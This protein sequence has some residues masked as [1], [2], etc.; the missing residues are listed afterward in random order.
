VVD[1]I[2]IGKKVQMG[3]FAA[4]RNQ[5]GFGR[6]V[7]GIPLFALICFESRLTKG[8]ETRTNPYVIGEK[9]PLQALTGP[10]IHMHTKH[11]TLIP[12]DSLSS[13]CTPH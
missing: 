5:R 9:Y 3:G 1:G 7:I 13:A 2:K 12:K 4:F 8:G 10:S 6:K 11:L